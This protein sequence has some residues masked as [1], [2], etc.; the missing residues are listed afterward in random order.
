[1]LKSKYPINL[2]AKINNFGDIFTCRA[3][4]DE[5]LLTIKRKGAEPISLRNLAYSRYKLGKKHNISRT[6]SWVKEGVLYTQNPEHRIILL[7]NSLILKHPKN[8]TEAHRNNGEYFP[9]V[10][11]VEEIIEKAH[12]ND[13]SVYILKNPINNPPKR[14]WE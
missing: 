4:Y 3:P 7:R 9:P 5:G 13:D 1:M 12:S 11:E 8:A 10:R 6:N 2:E 14:I